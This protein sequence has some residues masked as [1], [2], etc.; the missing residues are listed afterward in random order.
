M[1]YAEKIRMQTGYENSND[2]EKIQ[3]IFIDFGKGLSEYP[4]D[5]IYDFLLVK[6]NSL[7]T[8]KAPTTFLRPLLK[9]EK[10]FVVAIDEASKDNLIIKLP[11]VINIFK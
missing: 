5:V 6:P 9:N 3:S 4:V 1:L 10:K 8:I 2:F 11:R 7:K